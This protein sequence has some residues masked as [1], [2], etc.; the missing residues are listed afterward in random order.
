MLL[1]VMIPWV[2]GWGR[3]EAPGGLVL[4]TSAVWV[5]WGTP[6]LDCADGL[7]W[8]VKAGKMENK[9]TPNNT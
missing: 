4:R 3:E 9:K 5:A 6:K 1:G 2:L 7:G 8:L